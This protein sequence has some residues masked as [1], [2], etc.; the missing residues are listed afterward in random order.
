MNS[1]EVSSYICQ[2]NFL[3]YLS[4][5]ISD[6][7]ISASP[8]IKNFTIIFNASDDPCITPSCGEFKW[9]DKINNNEF[10]IQYFEEGNPI[11]TPL[12]TSGISYF[13]RFK[14]L[15]PNLSILKEF[16]TRA[17]T[18]KE[19]PDS[20]KITIYKSSHKGYFEQCC[21]IYSQNIDSGIYIPQEIKKSVLS[22]IDNFLLPN[23]KARYIK[24]GR[25][26]KTGIL[27]TG[28]PGTGKSALIKAI[29]AKYKRSVYVISFSK[30]L[31][32]D[33]FIDLIRDIKAD[34]ILLFEDID[35]YFVNREPQDINVSFSALL[36]VLDGVYSSTSGCI[37]FM[38][39]NNPDRL[40][41]ALIRPGRID[42]IIRFDYPKKSEIRMAFMDIVDDETITDKNK[43]FDEFYS[44]IKQIKIS[45]AG[46]ID[47]LFRYYANRDYITNIQE[48]IDQTQAFHEIVNDKTDKLYS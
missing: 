47:F 18:Y 45:M 32:D 48:L 46:I 38:T 21:K 43:E 16:V 6:A 23:T 19:P 25:C 13:K 29:A 44:H 22:H 1:I 14:V 5:F 39:A 7:D 41:P 17:I 40:D 28:V 27:L 24:F 11:S 12:E 10:I 20:D 30:K 37:T 42:K 15:H 35:A 8:D 31:D 2:I 26:Y 3:K 34:N 36:N 4:K 9:I 33:H